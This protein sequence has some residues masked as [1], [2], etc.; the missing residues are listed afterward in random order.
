ML[1]VSNQ[2]P[3]NHLGGDSVLSYQLAR[4]LMNQYDVECQVVHAGNNLWLKIT[5]GIQTS[6]YVIN[7]IRVNIPEYSFYSYLSYIMNF[8]SNY[9]WFETLLNSN[10]IDLIHLHNFSGF[11][12]KIISIIN[13]YNIPYIFT[14][15]DTWPFCSRRKCTTKSC[16]YCKFENIYFPP[17]MKEEF[18]QSAYRIICPSEYMERQLTSTFNLK[19]TITIYNS[20]TL[21]YDKSQKIRII[22]DEINKYKKLL[23]FNQTGLFIGHFS[24]LKGFIDIISLAEKLPTTLFI[25]VGGTNKQGGIIFKKNIIRIN[26][27]ENLNDIHE[28]YR[29]VDFF[30][31]PSYVENLPMTIIESLLNNTP[32]ISTNIGGIPEIIDSENSINGILAEPGDIN[33]FIAAINR[34]DNVRINT[35]KFDFDYF[36]SKY[37][38]IYQ[39][40]K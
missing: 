34:I 33:A 19:N 15:H 9:K 10:S 29:N 16:L 35:K 21:Y 5:K 3:P 7:D 23:S 39:N 22:I 17:T 31:L 4:G 32:V 11:G 2:F 36:I 8:S 12:W 27:L 26:R 6:P 30:L 40:S 38:N 14:L 20:T 37:Y 25:L 28:L 24:K 18:L 1:I 13:N